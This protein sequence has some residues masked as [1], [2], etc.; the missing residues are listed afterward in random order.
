MEVGLL[1]SRRFLS[2]MQP[3]GKKL[4]TEDHRRWHGKHGSGGERLHG[5]RENLSPE[6]VRRWPTRSR[7]LP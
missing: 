2:R 1:D 4:S 3:V 5:H 7:V 6:S